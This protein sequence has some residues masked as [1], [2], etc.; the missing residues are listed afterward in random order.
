MPVENEQMKPGY[1][2]VSLLS[3]NQEKCC[4]CCNDTGGICRT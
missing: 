4:L 2:S 1:L 3:G